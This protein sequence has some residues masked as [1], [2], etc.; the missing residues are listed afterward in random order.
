MKKQQL[1][2]IGLLILV[3]AWI[4]I[5][6]PVDSNATE[7]EPVAVITAL[8]EDQGNVD[9]SGEF[10]VRATRLVAQT[11]VENVRVRG[12]TQAFRTVE[13]RAEQSGRVVGTPV[14]RGSRVQAGDLLCE[15]AVDTRQAELQEALSRRDQAQL[16]YN[17]SQDLQRQNLLSDISVAQSR[18]AY[19][20][21][22]A[23]V[24][25]A[26][27]ALENTRIRAPFDGI[28]ESRPVEIGDLLDRGGICAAVLDD[29]PMLVVGLVPE[30]DVGKINMGAA[31]QAQ[32]LT[33]EI[34]NGTITYMSRA[35]DAQSRSYLIEAELNPSAVIPREGITAEI[36]VAASQIEAHRIPA[37]SLT[38]D[39]NGNVGVKILD[40]FNVVQFMPVRIVGDDPAQIDGALWVTGLPDP[41]TLI[42]H[43]HE[44]V[45]PGQSVQANFDWTRE[46]R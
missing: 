17:G 38:L 27:L 9:T 13:V 8:A 37:S 6:R 32:L 34:A 30:S 24:E 35:A 14:T 29:S 7:G 31:V 25:R 22:V 18:S 11:F 4:S 10:V 15:I 2:A 23:A 39:D 28:V 26:R 19:D 36:L 45:F 44:I 20:T 46:G 21:A 5:P 42:T 41:T 3:V 33:G 1:V 12:R 40:D 16:E 43:G